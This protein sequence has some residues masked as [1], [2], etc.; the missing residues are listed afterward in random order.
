MLKTKFGNVKIGKMGY[1]H[2]TSSKEG[3]YG[4]LWHRL[5]FKDFYGSEIPDGFIVHHK[6][7]N[8][9]DNCILNLQL[10]RDNEHKRLHNQG[11]YH[12]EETK[13][14]IGDANKNPSMET[15]NKMSEA[16]KGKNYGISGENHPMY[17]RRG[18]NNPNYGRKHSKETRRK[19]S[20]NHANVSGKNNPQSKYIVWDN[21]I[22][23]YQKSTMFK[24]GNEEG[25]NPRK[26]FK[27]KFEGYNVPIGGFN[28]FVSIEIIDNII[29]D[30]NGGE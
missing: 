29:K 12:S 11:N 3:N 16:K 1:Y 24:D 14:K 20:E 7:G 10:M 21:S 18:V 9:L 27:Y 19:M 13:R 30:K 23:N 26:C 15:R 25:L 8:K 6:N 22:V 2:V 28:E 17:N 5:I 4:K